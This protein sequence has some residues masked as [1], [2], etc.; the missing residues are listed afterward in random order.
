MALWIASLAPSGPAAPSGAEGVRRPQAEKAQAPEAPE[1]G[2]AVEIVEAAHTAPSG[3][4]EYYRAVR[5]LRN[6]ELRE[7]LDELWALDARTTMDV[8]VLCAGR[9][10]PT[11]L[12]AARRSEREAMRDEA[13]E[14]INLRASVDEGARE[15]WDARLALQLADPAA[16]PLLWRAAASVVGA[17]RRYA[18]ADAVGAGLSAERPA[19]RASARAA[20]FELFLQWFASREDFE[21]HWSLAAR[22]APE[23]AYLVQLA[24]LSERVHRLSVEALAAD[25]EQAV[26]G[27]ASVDPRLRAAA[28]GA[29]TRGVIEEPARAEA[30]SEALLARLEREEA[31]IA[32]QALLEALVERY[33]A[34]PPDAPGLRRL[35]AVLFGVINAGHPA[36]QVPVSQA[37]G[38]LP[39]DV[40]SPAGTDS[41]LRAVEWC[42]QQLED[43]VLSD[44]LVDGDALAGAL[45][46]LLELCER[47]GGAGLDHGE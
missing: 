37:L 27:L 5:E 24:A 10:L 13:R 28:A 42:V 8:A 25:A 31:P 36:F 22:R 11:F 19:V 47:A 35:R 3:L 2:G 29:L 38:R 33:A 17:G 34:V 6:S 18:L 7:R 9:G 14:W 20:L 45:R 40:A 39:W 30:V 26:A 32:F 21:A 44:A 15:A 46:S 16:R 43:P 1:V 23:E 41:L 4:A 12:T